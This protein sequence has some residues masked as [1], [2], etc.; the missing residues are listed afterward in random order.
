M[1]QPTTIKEIIATHISNPP[2]FTQRAPTPKPILTPMEDKTHLRPPFHALDTQVALCRIHPPELRSIQL[3]CLSNQQRR[4]GNDAAIGL[5]IR[6]SHFRCRKI[7]FAASLNMSPEV[8]PLLGRHT[9]PPAYEISVESVRAPEDD[10]EGVKMWQ[11][12]ARSQSY[13]GNKASLAT[14][15]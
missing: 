10:T 13:S 9:F 12:P 3:S 2:L 8:G 7:V 11:A 4:R 15:D 6:F 14:L 5:G 1:H